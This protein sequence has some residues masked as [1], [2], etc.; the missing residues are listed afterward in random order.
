MRQLERGGNPEA[1]QEHGD[2]RGDRQPARLRSGRFRPGRCVGSVRTVTALAKQY[3]GGDDRHGADR[4][5]YIRVIYR[6]AADERQKPRRKRGEPVA[7]AE[8]QRAV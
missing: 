1:E 6:P 4:Q 2:A 3:H 8:R 7:R 5:Y